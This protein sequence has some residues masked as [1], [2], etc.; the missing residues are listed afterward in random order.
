[1]KKPEL[2]MSRIVK[3]SGMTLVSVSRKTGIPYQKLQSSMKGKRKLRADEWMELCVL[4]NV[5]P[6]SILK[7]NA[8]A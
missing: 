1:M 3:D 2:V 8:T 5:E 4:F 6:I 7:E